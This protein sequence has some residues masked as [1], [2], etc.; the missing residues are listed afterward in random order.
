MTDPLDRWDVHGESNVIEFTRVN[1]M[2][3]SL[4]P[5]DDDTLLGSPVRTQISDYMLYF[6]LDASHMLKKTTILFLTVTIRE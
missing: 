6:H 2:V 4:S 1:Y 3:L 5:R